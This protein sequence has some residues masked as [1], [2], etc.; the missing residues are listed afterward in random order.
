[1]RISE[2]VGGQDK[3]AETALAVEVQQDN[4]IRRRRPV[5]VAAVMLAASGI[6]ILVILAGVLYFA[7]F[8]SSAVCGPDDAVEVSED[9]SQAKYS[10]ERHIVP[11]SSWSLRPQRQGLQLA[12]PT[13]YVVVKHTAGGRCFGLSDCT[14]VLQAIQELHWQKYQQPEISYNFLIDSSGNIY[15]G[16]GWNGTNTSSSFVQSCKV[17]VALIGNYAEHNVTR[18]MSSALRWLLDEG[19]RTGMLAAEYRLLAHNQL[20]KTLSPGRWALMEIADWPHRCRWY[21]YRGV[22]CIRP[23]DGDDSSGQ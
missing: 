5:W 19:V 20:K 2:V 3:H 15:E 6:I 23:A 12:H 17:E 21:C 9:V 22:H 8:S 7:D 11:H 18:Q 4:G 16:R 10:S 14:P 1:M 13:P